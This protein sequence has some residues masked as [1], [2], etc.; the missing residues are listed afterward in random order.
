MY[1]S[2]K[3]RPVTITIHSR[4]RFAAVIPTG[5]PELSEGVASV[6]RSAIGC[7]V[8]PAALSLDQQIAAVGA[9]GAEI[10]R[11][12]TRQA[13][14]VAAVAADPC[15]GSLAP[16][17][18]KEMVKE[19]LRACSASPRSASATGSCWPGNWC[20]RNQRRRSLGRE[21]PRRRPRPRRLR[22]GVDEVGQ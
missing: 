6:L 1:R 13:L 22:R 17:L 12:Q 15:A 20:K 3:R 7:G 21:I 18:N 9:F 10:A 16:D 2:P 19:E 14:L 11:L 8:D 4:P 5:D